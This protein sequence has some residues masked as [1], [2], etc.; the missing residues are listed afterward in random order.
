VK[1]TARNRY[2]TR[3]DTQNVTVNKTP[4][5]ERSATRLTKIT[6]EK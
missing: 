4:Q 5:Q 2:T 3:D 1:L 6:Q